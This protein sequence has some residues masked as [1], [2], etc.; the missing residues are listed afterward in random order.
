MRKFLRVSFAEEVI[1]LRYIES[2]VEVSK[3][4]EVT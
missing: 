3:H 1:G 2:E 4:K